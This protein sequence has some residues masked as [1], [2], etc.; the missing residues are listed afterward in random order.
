MVPARTREVLPMAIDI[1]SERLID[2]KAYAKLRGPGRNGKPMDISTFYRHVH[3]GVRGEFL[4]HAKIGGCT[5]TSIEAV[6]RF[7][8]RLTAKA[9]ASRQG[10]PPAVRRTSDDRVA[11]ALEGHGFA[12]RDPHRGEPSGPSP[13]S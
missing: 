1:S 3:A 7:V 2:A 11:R 13:M 9:T 10:R 4:E 12:T 5:Y 8:D 6:Q